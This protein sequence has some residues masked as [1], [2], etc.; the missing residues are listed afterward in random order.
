MIALIDDI[1]PTGTS[2]I[3]KQFLLLHNGTIVLWATG[4]KVRIA[5]K[6]LLKVLTLHLVEFLES[7]LRTLL[8][9]G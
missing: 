3:L 9:R 2:S 6:D 7:E 8:D 4:S 5:F 1:F